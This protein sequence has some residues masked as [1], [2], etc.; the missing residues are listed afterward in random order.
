[1]TLDDLAKA[2]RSVDEDAQI[3]FEADGVPAGDGFHI[4]EFK[5]AKINS[6]DCG[7]R[8]SSWDEVVFQ[9]L[10]GFGGKN[11]TAGRLSKI[12]SHSFGAI[13]GLADAPARAEFA[14]GNQGLHLFELASF[15]RREGAFVIAL[16]RSGAECKLRTR[17]SLAPN[18]PS[19]RGECCAPASPGH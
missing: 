2:L 14:F 12:L 16:G 3:V 5:L 17:P 7:G 19:V 18:D 15:Q 6:I 1:M 9:I 13:S 10:D 4:T 8:L 11:M